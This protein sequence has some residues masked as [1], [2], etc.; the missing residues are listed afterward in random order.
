MPDVTECEGNITWSVILY[1][2]CRYVRDVG[3]VPASRIDG[4]IRE[5]SV[6]TKI[7]ITLLKRIATSSNRAIAY[8]TSTQQSK[9]AWYRRWGCNYI[10]GSVS[11]Y[12]VTSVGRFVLTKGPVLRLRLQSTQSG[13]HSFATEVSSTFHD[14]LDI[15]STLNARS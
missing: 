3:D 13:F 2:R 11:G 14:Y 9:G 10:Y 5:A 1:Y 12:S 4:L 8:L 15:L 7:D 6:S